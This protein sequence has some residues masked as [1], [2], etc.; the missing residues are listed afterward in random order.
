MDAGPIGEPGLGK[1]RPEDVDQ[2]ESAVR[3]YSRLFDAVFSR[4]QGPFLFDQNG[5]RYADF[6]CSAGVLSYG[7]N[8]PDIREA[9]VA[10]IAGDGVVS[11]LDLNTTAK[12]HF[13]QKFR[14][15]ILEPRGLSYRVQTCGPTGTDAVEAALK[16]ARKVTGRTGIV[17]FT[18]AYHGVSLGALAVTAGPHERGAA[19]VPLEFV[20]RMPFD[21]YLGPEID[22]VAVLERMLSPGGGIE[23]PAAI[24]VETVQAEGGINVASVEWLR[25]LRELADRNEIVLI[26]DDI[27]VGCGRTGRFFSFERAGIAPD[28]VCLSKAIGGIG[29]PLAITLIRPELDCW[30]PGEHVGTFR[31]NNLAFVTGAAAFDYW[32]TAAFECVIERRAEQMHR[33]LRRIA[34]RHPNE[35]VGARGI[36]MIQGLHFRDPGLVGRTLECA[37]ARGLLMEAAGP[38]KNVTKLLPPLT[39][40]EADLAEGLSI[41][42]SAVDDAIAKGPVHRS[43]AY[44]GVSRPGATADILNFSVVPGSA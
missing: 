4:A 22:T 17:A 42:A 3:T 29:L 11:S 37:F 12:Q 8:N 40:E 1:D 35:L 44:S 30:E 23:R 10:Y 27:Q 26:V 25:S 34:E 7:H 31:G 36:G 38:Q 20:I 19:G 28:M 2:L 9:L 39:I 24:I 18:N 14:D 6:L 33:A 43:D 16:L 13:L 21:G 5:R 41:L 32:R 15:V